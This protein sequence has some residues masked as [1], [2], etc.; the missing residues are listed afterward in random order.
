MGGA[1]EDSLG[2]VVACIHIFL[3][4]DSLKTSDSVP[5][6]VAA[7]YFQKGEA[8][9]ISLEEPFY[10]HSLFALAQSQTAQFDV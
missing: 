4:H 5:H 6:M 1:W 3:P 10:L 7:K 2:D 8:C 9:C